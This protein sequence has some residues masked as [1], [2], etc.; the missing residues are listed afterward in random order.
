MINVTE[1][2]W[3]VEVLASPLPV[4][5]DF[6]ASWCGPCGTMKPRLSKLAN[7]HKGRIKVCV[8]DVDKNSDLCDRYKVSSIPAFLLFKDGK[9]IATTCGSMSQKDLVKFAE[10]A[11]ED[12]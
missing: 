10:K 9:K 7:T 6:T 1:E 12:K 5:V 2:G 11:L 4:L 8:V 3:K